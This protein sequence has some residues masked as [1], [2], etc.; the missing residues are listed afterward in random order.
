MNELIRQL[1]TPDGVLF[2]P[3]IIGLLGSLSFGIVGSYVVVRRISY[4]AH[5]IA[6]AV[7]LGIGL[8]LFVRHMT[9]WSGMTPLAGAFAAALFAAWIIG[10]STLYAPH[11]ADSVISAVTVLGLSGGLIFLSRTPGYFDPM[12]VLF[13]DILLVNLSDALLIGL[14]NVLVVLTG[15]LFYV[16]L[17]M[18]CF[19]EEFARLRG[20]NVE[21]WFVLLL[22][23]TAV[24]VV[25]MMQIVGLVLVTALLTLPAMTAL[26]FSRSLWQ[27]M[28]L[29]A[30]V[31]A[32]CVTGGL[33]LSYQLDLP[34]G[35]VIVLLA[36]AGYLLSQLFPR[37]G[38][39]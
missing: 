25:I 13:G 17:Q 20:I 12:S 32:A 31:C 36:G 19:D 2:F 35:P 24:T 23:L 1:F 16:R 11:R 21:F 33:A 7:L 14:L 10:T 8:A 39:R 27:A 18:V 15:L 30:L 38:A 3:L 37:R 29:A 34:S 6:H 4:A 28:G 9:A 5:G 26:R 22:M